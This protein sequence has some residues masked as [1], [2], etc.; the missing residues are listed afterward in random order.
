M[1]SKSARPKAADTFRHVISS[2]N[3]ASLI[4]IYLV[5]VVTLA[6]ILAT[7]SFALSGP[8]S[9]ADAPAA[10]RQTLGFFMMLTG[11]DWPS[12]AGESPDNPVLLA[13]TGA[14]GLIMP[15][16]FLGAVVFRVLSPRTK[17][18]HF[19]PHIFIQG[20]T[21]STLPTGP[22]NLVGTFHIRTRIPCFHLQHQVFMKY[23]KRWHEDTPSKG[24][25][26]QEPFPWFSE[27]IGDPATRGDE[28][29]APY[30][31][32]PT[33]F[34]IP[35]MIYRSRD[36]FEQALQERRDRSQAAPPGPAAPHGAPR[37]F[38]QR[39]LL[40]I[41]NGVIEEACIRT[42]RIHRTGPHD[43]EYLDLMVIVTGELPDAQASL[44]ELHRY[45]L[46]KV[47]RD[48]EDRSRWFDVDYKRK[49]DRYRVTQIGSPPNS[50]NHRED[51]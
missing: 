33:Q 21:S 7:I 10:A 11:Q 17:L 20:A 12:A 30:P 9:L 49:R 44:T 2:W 31:L 15:A 43:D 6:A 27:P 23:F 36:V 25:K 26:T 34:L 16:L 5:L 38:E 51:T 22:A 32:I 19:D 45:D 40:L 29:P 28:L 35:V 48:G 13:A 50:G 46:F 3:I 41:L 8:I 24:R 42:H 37:V 47:F 18:V 4:L 1:G 14:L 39:P